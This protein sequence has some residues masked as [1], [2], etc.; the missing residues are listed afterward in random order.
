VLLATTRSLVD[1][2]ASSIYLVDLNGKSKPDGRKQVNSDLFSSAEQ[3]SSV[4]K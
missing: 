1:L 4:K 3:G 2:H